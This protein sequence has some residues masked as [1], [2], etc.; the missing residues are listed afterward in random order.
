MNDPHE[1]WQLGHWIARREGGT[2]RLGWSGGELILRLHNGR[3]RFVEGVDP[4]ELCQRLSCEPLGNIDLLEEARGLAGTGQI[5]ET[6]AMGAAKELLQKSLRAW[7]LD[8]QRE[9]EI[10]EGEPNDVEGATISITHTLV[11]LVLSDTTG[12]LSR[13]ILP[14]LDVLLNRSPKFLDFYAP[15]RLSEEADLIVS[16]ITGERTAQ[17]VANRSTHGADEVV[18]LLAALVITGILEPEP[19]LVVS[20]DVDLLPVDEDEDEE[21]P[22]RRIPVAWIVAAAA[23][24]A[25]ALIVLIWMMTGSEPTVT[26]ETVAASDIGWGLVIDMGCEPQDLQRV[27]K[28]AQD[29]PKV[30]RPVA[31][32]SGEG[33]PC[34]QLVWGRFPNRAAAE[35]AAGAIPDGLSQQGFEPHPIELTG[36]ELEPPTNT[37]G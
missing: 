33:E 32:D 27:L 10:V 17:E 18:R 14:D 22:R 9:L 19:A 16:K 1:I 34:W 28:K 30:V 29:N 5:A 24:L 11:E 7:L 37:G 21:F 26:D 8:P 12:E 13:S 6:Y 4:S 20:G 31:I 3:I 36:E 2:A 23:A 25:V 35:G 15:L